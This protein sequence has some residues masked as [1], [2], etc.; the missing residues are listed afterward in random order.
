[1][2]HVDSAM[3]KKQGYLYQLTGEEGAALF[4]GIIMSVLIKTIELD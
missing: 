2:L 4:A 3:L 1:M